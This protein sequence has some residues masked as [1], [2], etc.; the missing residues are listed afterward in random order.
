MMQQRWWCLDC[1]GAVELSISGRCE[2]CDS[3][4]V[5]MMAETDARLETLPILA[6]AVSND[7]TQPLFMRLGAFL[8]FE[9]SSSA[10][11]LS[12]LVRPTPYP[13]L[14]VKDTTN[15]SKSVN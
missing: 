12:S 3:D 6:A 9:N 13:A 4:A 5:D 14:Q 8:R 11:L 15:E 1:R 7:N 10:S 2:V